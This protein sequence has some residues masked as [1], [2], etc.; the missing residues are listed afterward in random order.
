MTKWLNSFSP[1]PPFFSFLSPS[2]LGNLRSFS[3]ADT[4]IISGCDG[5]SDEGG[6]KRR[7]SRTNFNSWQ[8]EELER[9]FLSSHY[10][11]VFMREALAVRLELK[12]SRVAVSI[13]RWA[14][15]TNSTLLE[16][17]SAGDNPLREERGIKGGLLSRRRKKPSRSET[18]DERRY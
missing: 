2:H 8:L 4:F 18:S 11:D 14:T 16:H 3:N 6:S 17:H 12:E 1:L 7:R 10:P 5:E 9:A 13:S 15:F